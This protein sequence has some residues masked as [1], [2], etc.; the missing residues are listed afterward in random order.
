MQRIAIVLTDGY[1]DWESALLAAALR[2]YYGVEVQT[3]SP[4]GAPVIS[5]GGFKVNPDM[6]LDAIDPD[7]IDALVVNGGTAWD[8]EMVPGIVALLRQVH[9]AGKPV[10]AICGAVR[11]LA[12]SGLLDDIA[13][14]GNSAEELAA[15]A[16]YTGGAHFIARPAA[17]ATNHIV[18]AP[19]TAPVSFM[20]AVCVELGFGGPNLDYYVG[21]LGAEHAA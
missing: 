10:A 15:I 12:A 16:G 1:A 7:A 6:A 17:L 2:T 13:H 20:Q 4:D 8:G 3:A 14:T 19:G 11:A 21:M 5:A 18:T 9:Q